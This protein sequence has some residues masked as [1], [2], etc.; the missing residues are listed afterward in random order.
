MKKVKLFTLVILFLIIGCGVRTEDEKLERHE[1][2]CP[3]SGEA[4]KKTICIKCKGCS[5][6]ASKMKRNIAIISHGPF[7]PKYNKIR[8]GIIKP[9]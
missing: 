9:V 3:A 7:A 2:A 8:K 1:I 5:G 6:H 4:G